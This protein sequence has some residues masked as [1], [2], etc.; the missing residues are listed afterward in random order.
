MIDYD[1][2]YEEDGLHVVTEYGVEMVHKM[3]HGGK[4]NEYI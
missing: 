4:N 1:F 2:W 3:K